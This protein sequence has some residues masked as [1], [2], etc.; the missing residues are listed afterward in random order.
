VSL[1]LICGVIASDR[2]SWGSA[3]L[4]RVWIAWLVVDIVFGL[5]SAQWQFLKAVDLSQVLTGEESEALALFPYAVSGSPAARLSHAINGF[6]SQW[7]GA[8]WPLAGKAG[9]TAVLGAALALAMATFLG[10]EVLGI[11]ALGLLFGVGLVVACGERD[12][13]SRWLRFVQV[14]LAWGVG[15]RLFGS[16]R[17]PLVGLALLMGLGAYARD[18]FDIEKSAGFTHFLQITNWSLVV[19]L[20][21]FRQPAL[22][23]VTAIGSL[24]EA[25][26]RGGQAHERVLHRIPWLVSMVAAALAV[27]RW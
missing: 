20:L 14:S 9:L 16:L 21:L 13:L 5:I 4:L 6:V 26:S 1:S 3:Q 10:R 27:T 25:M 12:S 2:F 8:V 11:V 22:A 24:A 15:G 7:R 23:L 18:G 19:T 17:M